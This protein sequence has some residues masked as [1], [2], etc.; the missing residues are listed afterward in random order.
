MMWGYGGYGMPWG[1][2][3]GWIGLLL[4]L[5]FWGSIIFLAFRFI[6]GLFPSAT[7]SNRG[8]SQQ[9]RAI[10]DERYARGEITQDEY[11]RMLKD[12]QE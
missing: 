10:L 8:R 4:M 5:L 9:A 7:V 2:G 6:G 12:I 3:F 11:K 1:A